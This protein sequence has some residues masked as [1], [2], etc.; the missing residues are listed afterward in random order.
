MENID[1]KTEYTENSAV[2][3]LAEMPEFSEEIKKSAERNIAEAK[4]RLSSTEEQILSNEQEEEPNDM[5]LGV[6]EIA[7]GDNGIGGDAELSDKNIVGFLF[8]DYDALWNL[9]QS[10][11]IFSPPEKE[12]IANIVLDEY[13]DNSMILREFFRGFFESPDDLRDFIKERDDFFTSYIQQE[14]VAPP[15]ELSSND[16]FVEL[17]FRENH[18]ELIAHVETYSPDSLKMLASQI[19]NGIELP[20]DFGNQ[21]QLAATL[22]EN[23]DRF[24]S[25]EFCLLLTLLQDKGQY[26][27]KNRDG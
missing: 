11:Y 10:G 13:P 14:D 26:N 12:H 9:E 27:Q 6:Y 20:R 18:P 8:S 22:F 23:K 1:R 25:S 3:E 4:S 21:E 2:S 7:K 19:N 5:L 24:N 17:I 16:A 15:S